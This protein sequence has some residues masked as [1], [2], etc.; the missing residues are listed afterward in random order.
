MKG[1]YANRKREELFQKLK[2]TLG[3]I[4]NKSTGIEANLSKKS[5]DKMTSAKAL[6]KSKNNGFT[7]DEHFEFAEQIK[8]LYE[9][10]ILVAA[11]GNLKNPADP[12]VV[13]M[14]RFLA[15]SKLKNGKD[16]DILITVKESIANGHRIYSIELDE[17][18]KASERFQGLSDV[19]VNSEQGN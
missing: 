3:K 13:S 4:V 7:L 9:N 1:G 12:N 5:L 6:E 10:A 15:Q 11:H 14:K 2:T 8:T 19:A 17:I 18:N 16:A